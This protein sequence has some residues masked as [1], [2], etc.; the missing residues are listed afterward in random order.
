MLLA[1][2]CEINYSTEVTS[3][4]NKEKSIAEMSQEACDC[5]SKQKGDIDARMAPCIKSTTFS[6]KVELPEGYSIQDS[7]AAVEN[8][9]SKVDSMNSRKAADMSAMMQTMVV[10]CDAFGSEFETLYEKTYPVDSS[11]ANLNSIKTLESRFQTA[12]I[13]DTAKKAVLN[14]L[15]AKNI[16]ARRLAEGLRRCQQMKKLFKDESGAYYAS[17]FIYSLQGK[18]PLAINELAQ[19]SSSE[20]NSDLN[21][22]FIA[23]M[24][25]KAQ[26]NK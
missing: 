23:L 13:P 26:R 14:E 20:R 5:F 7:V 15:I 16:G 12:S 8:M 1:Y 2:S 17:A 4:E 19:E 25:R 22:M 6:Q 18:Y 21:K 3:T 24:K 11:V 9:K 10:S